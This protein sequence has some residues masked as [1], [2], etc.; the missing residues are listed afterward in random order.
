MSHLLFLL[1]SRKFEEIYPPE[2][3]EIV[4]FTDNSYTKTEVLRM[5]KIMLA[6]LDY[7]ISTPTV[8]TFACM[9]MDWQEMTSC[10]KNLAW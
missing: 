9:L 2:V 10:A 6:T 8:Q 4:S 1:L 7:N 5:E 3:H